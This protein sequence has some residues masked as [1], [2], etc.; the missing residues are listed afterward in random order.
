MRDVDDRQYE[1]VGGG[2]EHDGAAVSGREMGLHDGFQL[3]R[4][5]TASRNGRAI[6]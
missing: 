3:R 4:A 5:A 1:A 6:N 2:R